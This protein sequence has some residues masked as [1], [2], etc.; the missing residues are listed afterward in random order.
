MS[1]YFL[2]QQEIAVS[3]N[4]F[5]FKDFRIEKGDETGQAKLAG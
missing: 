4:L 1:Q 3:A 5:T 2:F